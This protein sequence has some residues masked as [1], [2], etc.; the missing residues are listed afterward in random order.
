MVKLIS[1]SR[2]T[3]NRRRDLGMEEERWRVKKESNAKTEVEGRGDE[4]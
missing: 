1:E 2:K 4:G 3:G